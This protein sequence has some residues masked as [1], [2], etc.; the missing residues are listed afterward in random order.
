MPDGLGIAPGS[1]VRLSGIGIGRV[2]H[3]DISGLMDPQ[4]IVRADLQI[5]A[6]FLRSIPSDSQTSIGADTLV[7][8][9]FIDIAEGKSPLPIA[10]GGELKSEPVKQA[11]ERADLVL[12]LQSEL[13]QA[14]RLLEQIGSPRHAD[15]PLHS[16]P[17]GIRR[18]SCPHHIVC[19]FHSTDAGR[20]SPLGAALFTNDL[21]KSIQTPIV[22]LDRLL[23]S[24]QRGEGQ[25]G[26]P[27]C[28]R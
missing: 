22:K 6:R 19:E 14:D 5:N 2:T 3:V 4:R 10:D 20:D 17:G 15:R 28:D 23:S 21:Y 27:V 12:S 11:S 13:R 24:I 18:R 25:A 7:G 26:T 9:R 16:G 8:Y 1:E